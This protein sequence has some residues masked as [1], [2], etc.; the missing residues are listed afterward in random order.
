MAEYRVYFLDGMSRHI[1]SAREIVAPDDDAA[2]SMVEHMRG[3][4]PIELWRERTR[5]Q[6]W[7]LFPR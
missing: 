4:S 2:V 6:R 7:E 3:L 5:I 1:I